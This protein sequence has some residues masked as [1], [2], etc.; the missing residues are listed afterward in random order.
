MAAK[1]MYDYLSTITPDYSTSTLSVTPQGLIQEDGDKH[2]VVH[3]S[4]DTS[5]EVVSISDSSIFHCT[6]H[7][8]H[9]SASDIGLIIES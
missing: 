6:L 5:E 2:Q 1:E 9:K 8:N 7:F 3:E 4:D